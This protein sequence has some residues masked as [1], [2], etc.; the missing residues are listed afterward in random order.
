[1]FQNHLKH[2]IAFEFVVI[3][4]AQNAFKRSISV[5]LLIV[6]LGIHQFQ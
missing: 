6:V 4:F 1:M 2:S 3:Q 5:V